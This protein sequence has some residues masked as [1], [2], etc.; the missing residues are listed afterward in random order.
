MATSVNFTSLVKDVTNYLERG[1]SVDTDQTV[2]EQIPRLINAA[3][4]KVI[5]TLKLLGELTPLNDVTGLAEGV[6][7]IPKPDRWRE[8]VSMAYGAGANSNLRTPLFPRSYEY[9]RMFWPDDSVK[10]APQFY[11]DYDLQHY[12][13]VPTPD[14]TYPLELLAYLQPVFLD[15]NNQTNFFSTY[16]PNLLLY[17]T[18]LE[19]APFLKNDERIGT[20]QTF[21]DDE[22]ATLMNQDLQRIMDRATQRTRP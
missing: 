11:A 15:E 20:W 18:L 10:G 2:A 13:I 3:E 1:G 4:R 14:A 19:A 22:I 7:V 6:S 9:C 17:Q 16:T 21:A 8:T 12:L 5:Q